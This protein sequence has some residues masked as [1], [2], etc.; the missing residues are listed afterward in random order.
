MKKV[1]YILKHFDIELIKF[2]ISSSPIE[3]LSVKIIYI[4]DKYKAL[5]PTDLEVTNNGILKWLKRRVIP[6]NRAF[7]QN[8]LAKLG[9]NVNDTKGI[10]E[11][12]K[13]L[14][15]ND[16]KW[17]VE[18]TFEGTFSQYNLYDNRFSR[19]L[20]LIAYTGYGESKQSK[21]AST[22]ELTTDGMLAKCWRRI[23]G[24]IILYKA[25]STG[26]SN[27]GNEPFSEFYT[28]QIAEAM[29]LNA[30]EYN[31]NKWKG[32]LFSTCKLFTSKKLS[33]IPTGRIVTEGGWTAVIA[34]YKA[35]GE[36]YYESLVDML[37]FDTVICNEDRHFGN[38][39]LLIDNKTN[40]IIDTAPIFDNGLA[41]FNYAM[42]DDLEDIDAYSQTRLMAT[43]QDFLIFA[44]EIITE[45]QKKKLLK[46]INFKFRKHSTYNLPP[47]RLII[48][49]E[50]IQK[51]VQD[52]LKL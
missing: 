6:K 4:N 17:I 12:C 32:Q 50:F 40:N 27:T 28:F 38:F 16:C 42:E 47:Q 39:G 49:E 1:N 21:F 19:I 5:F 48:I 43:S 45:K 30:I 31:L 20:S 51:R 46:L 3:G 15:L 9:L 36:K 44:K 24:N 8:F 33:Y 22:P 7:V 29:G 13:G 35:L 52:L 10:I 11:I 18:D 2:S 37:I 26:A 41:L 14:S 34:Y 25:G 23:N